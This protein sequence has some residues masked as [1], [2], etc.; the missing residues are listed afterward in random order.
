MSKYPKHWSAPWRKINY[1]YWSTYCCHWLEIFRERMRRVMD[2]IFFD[3]FLTEII[4]YTDNALEPG[5][6]YWPTIAVVT[7]NSI[8]NSLSFMF[9]TILIQTKI[10]DTRILF[11]RQNIAE[12][13][14]DN[15]DWAGINLNTLLNTNCNTFWSAICK[16][17]AVVCWMMQNFEFFSPMY[18]YFQI[19]W[20]RFLAYA[21]P[22]KWKN[23]I[24]DG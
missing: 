3:T 22:Y 13:R 10:G 19:Q 9:N 15:I 14:F 12:M 16:P 24:L 4:V 5:P 18:I 1:P 20:T 23:Q 8:M 7:L 17:T 2:I 11:K 21:E 6:K